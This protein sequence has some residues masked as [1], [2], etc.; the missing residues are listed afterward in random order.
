[1]TLI[2]HAKGVALITVMLILALATILAVSMS[3]RQQLNIHRSANVLNFEQAYQYVLGAEAW[4]KQ[5]LKRDFESNKTDS[6]SDD[7]ATVLPPLP[8]EGGQMSGQIED[9]QARFNINNLVQNGKPQ[10]LYIERFKRLL[11]NIELDEDMAAVIVDWLD[12]NVETGFSG[13]E[14]NEY[15]NLTPAYRTA[16]QAMADVSELL[17]IKGVDFETYEKLRPFVCVLQSESEINVNT[18]SAEVLSSIVKD[19]SLEDAKTLIEA[20]NKEAHEKLEDFL[21][22]PLLKQKKVKNEGLSVS[23]HFFQLNSTAQ[24]ERISV[25]YTTILQRESDGNVVI[26]KRSRGV[27]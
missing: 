27:L 26:L 16:N 19:I 24:I 2:R 17:L 21:Q 9:L 20:R 15:L 7:W 13:A 5:I 14:D 18:A 1:M 6:S 23:S 8:I 10:S 12:P 25:E 4:A 3:S 11:R 22:H